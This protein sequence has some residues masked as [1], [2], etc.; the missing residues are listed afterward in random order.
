M[1]VVRLM[2]LLKMVYLR[3]ESTFRPK[4][5]RA[6]R[7]GGVVIEE[8]IQ[9]T[10][11]AFFALYLFIFAAA[12]LFISSLGLSFQTSVSAV[13]ATLNNIG[14]GLEAV[15]AVRDYTVV[16]PAGK[17][18]LSLCMVLGRLE[19]FSVLVLFVPSFW[20]RG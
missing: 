15:G 6:L 1:K 3:L 14:P 16:P 12:T 18:V 19:L 5:V 11:Y 7:V 13:A 10:I 8:G 9:K 17:L 4:S 2:V 20:R